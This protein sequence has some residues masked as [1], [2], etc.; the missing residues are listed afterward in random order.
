MQG[1]SGPA[2]TPLMGLSNHYLW[3]SISFGEGK[4]LASGTTESI[5][6]LQPFGDSSWS[7]LSAEFNLIGLAGSFPNAWYSQDQPVRMKFS[8]ENFR[9]INVLPGTA[10]TSASGNREKKRKRTKHTTEVCVWLSDAQQ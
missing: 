8:A 6:N 2:S 9:T 1:A 10:G 7:C 4:L 5:A 3:D